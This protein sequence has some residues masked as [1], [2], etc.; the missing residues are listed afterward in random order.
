MVLLI[1]L[2]LVL[3]GVTFGALIWRPDLLRPIMLTLALG[4]VGIFGWNSELFRFDGSLEQL[5]EIGQESLTQ[6]EAL[7]EEC[8]RILG[9]VDQLG[10]LGSI[11]DDQLPVK[12]DLWDRLP[13]NVQAAITRCAAVKYNEGRELQIDRQ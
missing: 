11:S 5:D 12:S 2:Q 8:D 13:A 1:I 6:D 9:I 10:L 3:T 7:V 4:L